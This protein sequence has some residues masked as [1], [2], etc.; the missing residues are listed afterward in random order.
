MSVLNILT[1]PNELLRKKSTEIRNPKDSEIQELIFDMLETMEKT[2]N[3][4]GLAAPQVGKLVQL[5]IIKLDGKTY[6][7]INPKI[8]SHSWKK[9]VCEEGCLSFPGKFIPLK[10]SQKVKVKAKNRNGEEFILKANG[11]LARALQHEIDHLRGILFI[12]KT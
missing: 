2:G 9:E 11:L 1:Y 6:I 12:D 7:L 4:L 8:I 5:C 10:R 3:A